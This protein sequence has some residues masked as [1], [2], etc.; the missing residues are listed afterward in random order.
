MEIKMKSDEIMAKAE[1]QFKKA[2]AKYEAYDSVRGS[3]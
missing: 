2:K 1:L 3:A